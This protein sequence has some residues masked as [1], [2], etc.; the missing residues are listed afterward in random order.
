MTDE[1]P[2]STISPPGIY[3]S[4]GQTSTYVQGVGP[5]PSPHAAGASSQC[6]TVANLDYAITSS[7]SIVG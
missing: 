5:L 3:V 1:H 4:S 7:T 6:S 2:P